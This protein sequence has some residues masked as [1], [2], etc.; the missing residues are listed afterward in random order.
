MAWAGSMARRSQAPMLSTHPIRARR[1]ELPAGPTGGWVAPAHT[2]SGDA[3]PAPSRRKAPGSSPPE[4]AAEAR[5]GRRAPPFLDPG[6]DR[7]SLRPGRSARSRQGSAASAVVI[8]SALAAGMAAVAHKE[9][10]V[11]AWEPSAALFAAIGLPVNVRGLSFGALRSAIDR[12]DT[13]PIL[14]LE[15][16]IAN[17]R[18]RSVPVPAL[19]IALRD[20]KHRE[21]Y[22]WMTAAPKAALAPGETVAFRSRL[23]AAPDQAQD[24]V[25]SFAD[26]GPRLGVDAGSR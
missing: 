15:G 4:I 8:V 13:V 19:R 5:S 3:G 6:P 21:L 23:A 26:A 20:A 9:A 16:T 17:I 22:S 12:E 14:T 18:D 24:V 10:V 1:T 2:R 7:R 11:R 25:V